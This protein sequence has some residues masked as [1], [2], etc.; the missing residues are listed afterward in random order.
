MIPCHEGEG[1]S[2]R[3]FLKGTGPSGRAPINVAIERRLAKFAQVAE[4]GQRRVEYRAL[5][6]H[7][8]R[9]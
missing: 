1:C 8:S 6:E 5:G 2:C 9:Q 3:R 7:H 4:F